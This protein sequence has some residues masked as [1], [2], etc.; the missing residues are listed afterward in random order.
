M[1]YAAFV[2]AAGRGQPPPIALLHGPDAQ[3]LDDALAAAT[4]GLFRD[5]GEAALGREVLEGSEVPVEDVVRAASTLPF[6]TTMR[7]IAVRRC[8]GLP[9]KGAE[10]LGAYARDPNPSTCL[11]LL[12]DEPLG[13]SRDRRDHW[14]LGAI[15]A[16]AVIA[17]PARDGRSAETWLRQRA[18]AEG[19]TVSDEAA[20]LLVQWVGD[21]GASLLGETRKAALA[22]G[23]D[24]TA[25]GVNEVT[26]VV[27]EHRLSGVF[28]LTRAVQRREVGVALRTLDRLLATEEP[29]RLLALLTADVRATLIVADLNGRGQRVEDIARAVRK[30]APVVDMIARGPASAPAAVLARRLERCWEAELR[31]KSS[32]DARAELT[33]LVLD[34]CR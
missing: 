17:L 21:D 30:P 7:L 26:A 14:L 11:L 28:D 12:A 10:A 23:G 3:L 1:D 13:A 20:R 29:I 15:P 2:Q 27:G 8:Q 9:A 22:G 34:L 6:M 24:N 4:R 19:L 32:G 31:L 18:A 5:A 33:A 16:P 25:V